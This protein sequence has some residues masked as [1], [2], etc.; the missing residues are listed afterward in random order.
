MNQFNATYLQIIDSASLASSPLTGA[1]NNSFGPC[2]MSFFGSAYVSAVDP[3][4]GLSPNTRVL[5]SSSHLDNLQNG[6]ITGSFGY[7]W[8]QTSNLWFPNVAFRTDAD[9][10]AVLQFNVPGT[11]NRGQLFNG[12]TWDRTRSLAT[13][14]DAQVAAQVGLTGSVA[15]LQAFNGTTFDRVRSQGNNAD[16]IAVTTLGNVDTV[17]FNYGFNGTTWDRQRSQSNTADAVAGISTG[18]RVTAN[19]PLLFN[20][21][22]FDRQRGTAVFKTVVITAAGNTTVWT[23]T[24]GKKF[25]LMGYSISASGTAASLVANLLKLQDGAAGTNIAQHFIAIALTVTGDTQI[26]ADLGQGVLSGAVDTVLNANLATAL[27]AGGIA[28]NAWGT[29]E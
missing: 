2:R 3:A 17:S 5:D 6:M 20:G 19:Y 10:Q 22:T 25:R 13:N 18:A 14:S 15:R 12:T 9:A 26:Y 24:S 21:S 7:T 8:D 27:T 11:A 16:A 1:I 4:S 28:I 29:E 23:P